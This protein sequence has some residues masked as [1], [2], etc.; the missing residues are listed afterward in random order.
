MQHKPLGR[1]LY[2][3]IPHLIGSRRGPT[4]G[5]VHEG[6]HRICCE[7]ARDRRDRIIVTEKL[8]GSCCGVANVG[9]EIV[10]LTRSGLEAT[11]SHYTQHHVFAEWVERRSGVF[12]ACLPAGQRLAGEWLWQAH[13]T[14]YAGL[15][16]DT[17]F[18]AFDLFDEDGRRTPWDAFAAWCGWASIPLVPLLSDGPPLSIADADTLLGTHG[19]YGATDPAEGA[20]WRVER[21]GAFDFAAKYVRPGKVDGAYLPEISGGEAVINLEI[22]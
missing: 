15:T 7:R 16:E 22:A 13:G 17:L 18:A 1:R 8:D 12:M 14:R 3:S 10:A 2:G 4:D 19:A 5:G 21:D 20:V 6:Q 11:H 9:G